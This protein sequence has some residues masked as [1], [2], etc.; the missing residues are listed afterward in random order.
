MTNDVARYRSRVSS[1]RIIITVQC[2][3]CLIA[4]PDNFDDHLF[5][6]SFDPELLQ[7]DERLEALDRK[8]ECSASG[9]DK[10]IIA[11]YLYIIIATM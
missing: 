11:I 2:L 3:C 10:N 4:K 9:V 1:I 6:Q 8:T 5:T 7:E